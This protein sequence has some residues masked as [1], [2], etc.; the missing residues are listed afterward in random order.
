[1]VLWSFSDEPEL[2]WP[3]SES[4]KSATPTDAMRR[5]VSNAFGFKGTVVHRTGFFDETLGLGTPSGGG[6]DLDYAYRALRQ[7]RVP[8]ISRAKLTGHRSATKNFNARVLEMTRYWETAM[9]VTL[10]HFELRLTPLAVYRF[11]VGIFFLLT[12]RITMKRF[13]WPFEQALRRAS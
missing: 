10:A 8:I 11:S 3:E 4:F 7:S 13:F 12:R 2:T 6:E 9:Y 5:G 1:M